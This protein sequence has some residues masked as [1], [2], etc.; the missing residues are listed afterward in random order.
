MARLPR[1]DL[2]CERHGAAADRSGCTYTEEER[3]ICRLHT[4][5][6]ETEEAAARLGTPRGTY[7][8]LF[9]PPPWENGTEEDAAVEEELSRLLEKTAAAVL[10]GDDF[11]GRRILVVGLGNRRMTA[12]AV[13]PRAA[14]GI[15]ATA[16]LRAYRP[17]LLSRLLCAEVAVMVPGVMAQSGMESADLIRS[18]VAVFRPHLVLLIDALAA[19]S[20]DRLGTTIQLADSGM[21]PGSGIGN[22]RAPLSPETLGCP[23]ISVGVPTVTDTDTL[24]RDRLEEAGVTPPEDGTEGGRY[25][26]SPRDADLLTEKLARCIAGAVN[27]VFGIPLV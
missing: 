10:G 20:F 8:T 4:L 22:C 5:H 2:A 21:A 6:V 11:T 16:H 27:T 23:V 24:L 3:G 15:T 17:S 12:D 14:D 9:F 19:R 18:A 25:F 1:T 13:G 26:V 7:E